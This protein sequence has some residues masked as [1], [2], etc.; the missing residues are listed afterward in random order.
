[1]IV[2]NSSQ[3]PL[4][5]LVSPTPAPRRVRRAVSN[6]TSNTSLPTVNQNI[7]RIPNPFICLEIGSSILF[8]IELN[9][10][11]RSLS[12]YPRYNKDHLFNQNDRFDY[13]N[14]RLLHSLI[15]DTNKTVPLFANVFAE[16][17]VFVFY[18]NAEPS[19]EMIVKV[20]KQGEKCQ[21]NMDNQLLPSSIT[22]LT[23]YGVAKSEVNISYYYVLTIKNPAF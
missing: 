2:T 3:T 11:N 9:N 1:M 6:A 12:H 13:G 21:D 15:Q 19:H 23:G 18:D 4:Q 5:P 10:Q 16:A 8:K 17:G 14:F 7:E 20:T 22:T